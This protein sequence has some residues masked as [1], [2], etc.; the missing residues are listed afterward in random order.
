MVTPELQD[1]L[2]SLPSSQK[3]EIIQML[4]HSLELDGTWPGI[5][6]TPGVMGGEACIRESRIPVWLMVS[7]RRM[8]SSEAEILENYPTLMAQDLVNAWCYAEQY[9]EEIDRAIARQEED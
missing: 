9:A 8:G 4:V 3:T 5:S 7:Y 1:Q 6:K 2:L